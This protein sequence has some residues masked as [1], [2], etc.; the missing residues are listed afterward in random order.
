MKK[1]LE[2]FGNNEIKEH[3][4]KESVY[5]SLV[6]KNKFKLKNKFG[7]NVHSFCLFLFSKSSK[8]FA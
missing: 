1:E 5:A 2:F 6:E 4:R 8:K 3:L 7:Y